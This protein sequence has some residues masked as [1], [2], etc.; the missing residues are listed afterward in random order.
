MSQ[1]KLLLF[2]AAAHYGWRVAQADA[3]MAFLNGKL[4]HD[5]YMRQPTGFEKG[6]K[7]HLVCRLRQALYG[8]VPALEFGMILYV[9]TSK[10]LGL[11]YPIST[12]HCLYTL[13]TLRIS[14]F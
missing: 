14:S 13:L 6:E 1:T 2:A 10:R 7:G 8:L 12:P 11:G 4:D 3:V 5:V 9:K